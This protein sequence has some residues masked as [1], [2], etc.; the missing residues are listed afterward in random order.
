MAAGPEFHE[1]N[2]WTE[3]IRLAYSIESG[4]AEMEHN[5]VMRKKWQL[6]QSMLTHSGDGPNLASGSAGPETPAKA[7]AIA[8]PN[9][10]MASKKRNLDAEEVDDLPPKGTPP[11]GTRRT[12]RDKQDKGTREPSD[13][14]ALDNQARRLIQLYKMTDSSAR[15]MIADIEKATD[16]D[17]AWY[18][19]NSPGCLGLLKE[20]Y[21]AVEAASQ[22][23]DNPL[24]LSMDNIQAFKKHIGNVETF[25]VNVSNF[26]E[27]M[28]EPLEELK[29]KMK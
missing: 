3:D 19:A 6:K 16:P 22:K 7:P 4:T 23:D 8:A 21:A 17:D 27:S 29:E 14:Q 15:R 11:K 10:K 2:P 13:I 18:W 26:I 24:L 25:A 28:E 5:Y 9:P 12:S 20:K 1:I